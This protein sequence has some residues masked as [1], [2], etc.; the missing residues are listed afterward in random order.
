MTSAPGPPTAGWRRQLRYLL[1]YS[2]VSV[3]VVAAEQAV[4][5]VGFGLLL[6][7]TTTANLV[8]FALLTPPGYYLNRRWV[9]GE[10]A[11]RSRLLGQVVPFWALGFLGLALSTW[12]TAVVAGRTEGIADR[13]VQALFVN[14]ASL[15]AYGVVWVTKFAVLT[16]FVFNRPAPAP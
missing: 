11:G 14:L 5:F 2:A 9:W 6:W 12:A 3:G 7:S 10:A 16:R 8:A 13:E 4:L 15:A 1:K